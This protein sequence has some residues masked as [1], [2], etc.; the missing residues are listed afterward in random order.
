M[1]LLGER[2]LAD[3]LHALAPH[4]A[5]RIRAA[6]HPQRQGMTADP[7]QRP[8]A[9]DHLG[10]G[11]VRAARTE[12]R[13]P[14][15]AHM[16]LL[17]RP[18]LFAQEFRP[19]LHLLAVDEGGDPSGQRQRQLRRGKLAIGLE[20]RRPPLVALAHYPRPHRRIIQNI[21]HLLLDDR[22]LLLDHHDLAQPLGKRADHSGIDRPHQRQLQHPHPVGD[23][24]FGQRLTGIEIGFPRRDDADRRPRRAHHDAVE[25]V[26]P[27]IGLRRGQPDIDRPRLLIERRVGQ[28]EPGIGMRPLGVADMEIR[29][30]EGDGG[31]T[32]HHVAHRLEPHPAA[33]P[34]RHRP[35][36]QPQLQQIPHIRRHQDRHGGRDQRRFRLM[37]HGRGLAAMVIPRHHQHPPGPRRA[38]IIGVAERVPRPIDPRP[39]AIPIGEHPVIARLRQQRDLLRPPNRGRRDLLVHRRPELDMRRRKLLLRRPHL[40]VDLPQRRAAIARNEPRRIQPRRHVE[41]A[42]QHRQPH[43]RLGA[44]QIEPVAIDLVLVLERDRRMF[45]GRLS[46][47]PWGD[48]RPDY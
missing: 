38:G 16:H 4:L 27:R 24:K 2:R 29:Q 48:I 1:L 32:I 30:I 22:R 17:Q 46:V 11:V 33:R 41:L 20:E 40:D 5:Q 7:G 42:L 19:R 15:R 34:A 36:M 47:S 26:R 6:V 21:P 14:R 45:H 31:R 25:P 35:A 12:K 18:R 3:P 39:L 13:P 10:R 8:A 44:R 37:R 28:P 9:V 23:A 43:Q